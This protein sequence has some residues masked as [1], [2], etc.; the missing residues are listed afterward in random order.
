MNERHQDVRRHSRSNSNQ[1]A[2]SSFTS[3]DTVVFAAP[4]TA[5]VPPA[6]D[7]ERRA[8][9]LPSSTS[10]SSAKSASADYSSSSLNGSS[11]HSSSTTTTNT[12]S[13]YDS[14]SY[15]STDNT[16]TSSSYSSY[17]SSTSTSPRD[18]A[19]KSAAMASERG[20]PIRLKRPRELKPAEGALSALL[21]KGEKEDE[22]ALVVAVENDPLLP[23]PPVK[24]ERSEGSGELP[25]HPC[26]C[27]FYCSWQSVAPE[28]VVLVA[29][30]S[31]NPITTMHLRMMELARDAVEKTWSFQQQQ[32]YQQK[33]P[34]TDDGEGLRKEKG[35]SLPSQHLLKPRRQVV[36]V[37]ILSPVSDAYAKEGL[38]SAASRCRLARLACATTSDWLAVDSWEASRTQWT[39]T[40]C[41]L[42]RIR[43]RMHRIFQH[44]DGV[45]GSESVA[46]AGT[47]AVTFDLNDFEDPRL[48]EIL[49]LQG[50]D[51]KTAKTM[52][53]GSA[54]NAWLAAHLRA[55]RDAEA[56]EEAQPSGRCCCGRRRYPASAS[57][58]PALLPVRVKLVC[59]ADLLE[60]F[61][62]PNLWSEDD[63][64]ALVRDYGI[65]CI[66][67]PCSNAARLLYEM[68]L[69]SRYEQNVILA[70]EWC[71]NGLSA[72]LVRRALARGQSVRYLVPEAALEEIYTHGLYGAARPPRLRP[73]PS[74]RLLILVPPPPAIP[75]LSPPQ[76]KEEEEEEEA[77]RRRPQHPS[78]CVATKSTTT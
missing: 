63:M 7:S 56:A 64:T 1:S 74:P 31:F 36:V 3:L 77:L 45:E 14:S 34:Q 60:S 28:P 26:D 18:P 9:S 57:A 19:V 43:A 37:G 12:L 50:E 67:R 55:V 75:S 58:P 13:S 65:V 59:G 46:V 73:R 32:H 8:R 23:P 35:N 40:R 53:S 70:T 72:T 25:T 17:S 62:T 5:A 29:C 2:S 16:T 47:E 52:H 20:S 21:G 76:V 61:N 51:D 66:S 54:T 68:D 11:T 71:Q 39:P 48:G 42:E 15:S 78:T 69:L 49:G 6:A 38:A 41:V 24:V 4:T 27:R 30:G 44:L 10:N 22:E 33:L